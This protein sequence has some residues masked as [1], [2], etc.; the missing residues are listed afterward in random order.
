MAFQPAVLQ[1]TPDPLFVRE[2]RKIDTDLRVV[3]GYERYLM[4]RWVIERRMSPER[5]FAAYSSLLSSDNPRFIE[6]P[7]YDDAQPEYDED[8]N[9]VGYKVVGYRKFDLAPEWEYVMAVENDDKTFRELD[10]RTLLALR[11]TYAWERFH[12]ITR[13]KME[14][15]RE[16]QDAEDRA[17]K[18]RRDD[19]K[20]EILERKREIWNLPFTG[21]PTTV[22]EGTEL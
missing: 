5:Y 19:I 18:A 7:I 11:R 16:R 14:K 15:E 22:M 9:E 17:A 6:Q 3:F 21:Q 1:P 4:N 2:L 20:L 12:S 8:G 10:S 13:Y